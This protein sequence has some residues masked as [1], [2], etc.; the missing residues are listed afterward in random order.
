LREKFDQI[1]L[2]V[3]YETSYNLVELIET[4]K[5]LEEE[6]EGTFEQDELVNIK[7]LCIFIFAITVPKNVDGCGN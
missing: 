1:I 6:F 7:N 4:H 2:K 3:G 5:N